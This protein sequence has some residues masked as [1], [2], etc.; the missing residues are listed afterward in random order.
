LRTDSELLDVFFVDAETGWAVGDRG[1]IWH[2]AD[3]GENWLPQESGTLC[4]LRSVFFLDRSTGWTAGGFTEPYTHTT[5]GALL[6]TFDGGKTWAEVS[7]ARLPSVLQ[8]EFFDEKTG[9]AVTQSCGMFPHGL[10]TTDDGGRTWSPLPAEGAQA[11]LSGDFVDSRSGAVVGRSGVAAQIDGRAVCRSEAMAFGMRALNRVVLGDNDFGFAAGEGGLLVATGNGGRS[12]EDISAALGKA[13]AAIDFSAVSVVGSHVWIAG[14]PGTIVFHSPN[15]GRNWEAQFTSQPL[16]IRALKFVD[17]RHG[18][19][20]GALGM[21]L[22]TTDGGQTWQRQKGSRRRAAWL[23]IF[24]GAKDVPLEMVAQLAAGEGYVG[25]VELVGR[26]DFDP[27]PAAAA[28]RNER[29]SEALSDAGADSVRKAWR[30]P[31]RSAELA[32]PAA[33]TTQLWSAVNK[34]DGAELLEDEIARQIRIW[35]PEIVIAMPDD[36]EEPPLAHVIHEATL[37]AVAKAGADF[38]EGDQHRWPG[39]YPWKVKRVFASRPPNVDGPVTIAARRV[40]PVLQNSLGDFVARPRGL[41]DEQYRTSPETQSF[42]MVADL[43]GQPASRRDFFGGLAIEPGGDA[44]REVAST[45]EDDAVET[46]RAADQR[47]VVQAIVASAAENGRSAATTMAQINRF[48]SEL[49]P[50]AAGELLLQLGSLFQQAGHWSL[51]AE[52]FTTLVNQF[53]NHELCPPAMVWLVQYYASSE[54]QHLTDASLQPPVRQVRAEPRDFPANPVGRPEDIAKTETTRAKR[55]DAALYWAN[56]LQQ[57]HAMLY[58]EPMVRFPLAAVYRRRGGDRD[59]ERFYHGI[60]SSRDHDAWWHCATG[61]LQRIGGEQAA[62][63]TGDARK[64]VLLCRRAEEKPRLDGELN[65]SIWRQRAEDGAADGKS[66]AAVL[67]SV[68]RDDGAWPAAVKLAYDDEFLYVA[69]VCRKAPGVEYPKTDKPRERDADLAARDRIELLI[70]VDRDWTTYYQLVIDH[71]GWTAE[72]C[73]GAVAWNP[74]WY[75]AASDDGESWICEVAIPLAEMTARPSQSK[76]SWVVGIQ[77]TVPGVG[78]QSWTQP[79]GPDILGEGFGYLEF[80]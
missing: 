31:V 14:S 79:A 47:R 13:A 43:S 51:A 15:H 2:S 21:I 41:L 38:V 17:P 4:R 19:A 3:G 60:Q 72:A 58:A 54:L 40:V 70:D 36:R 62:A 55:D 7:R 78:F 69:A 76:A 27:L 53:P 6:R 11:W 45:A 48:A 26:N 68:H 66:A 28:Y 75:V 33:A 22:A 80:E 32:I 12:W 64:A 56:K 57:T 5:R 25:A 49:K 42:K 16:P 44:R 46:R 29:E 39:L 50:A 1:A 59:A 10:L 52:T 73:C 67:R 8:I 24:A 63:D 77:R 23:G 34:A 65:E 61:E 74:K 20:V 37:R 18:W 71:R 9:W 35:R 30:F